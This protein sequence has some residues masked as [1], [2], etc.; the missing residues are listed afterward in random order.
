[1]HACAR[2]TYR[3]YTVEE[4]SYENVHKRLY[5]IK[6]LFVH[7]YVI[8]VTFLYF[9]FFSLFFWFFF[10]SRWNEAEPQKKECKIDNNVIYE[11]IKNWF[12]KTCVV[13]TLYE[14][15]R[16]IIN[17]FNCNCEC[18]NKQSRNNNAV[19]IRLRP[20][21][22]SSLSQTHTLK[23][24]FIWL[25]VDTYIVFVSVHKSFLFFRS[26]LTQE[27]FQLACEFLEITCQRSPSI[28]CVHLCIKSW[29]YKRYARAHEN[30]CV[31]RICVCVYQTRI[32]I[33]LKLIRVIYSR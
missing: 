28:Y 32:Q 15:I 7:T 12:Q 4:C 20:N 9:V 18:R 29:T 11:Q 24:V 8:H 23:L 1:M 19:C 25:N 26:V 17:K 2:H 31:L 33:C 14:T 22:L 6:L 16:I 5:R 27:S 30:K 3:M 10:L 13:R 21:T